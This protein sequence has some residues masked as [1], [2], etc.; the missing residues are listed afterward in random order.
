MVSKDDGRQVLWPIY[1]DPAVPR[2]G[3]RRVPS[4]WAVPGIDVKMIAEVAE[5]LGLHPSIE[6]DARHPRETV[7]RGRVLVDHVQEKT[8]TIRIIAKRLRTGKY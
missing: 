4:E 1:F 7:P 3:G 5:A 8:R 6:E 2:K